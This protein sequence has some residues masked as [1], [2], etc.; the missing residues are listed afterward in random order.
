MKRL[1]I[2]FLVTDLGF[3]GNTREQFA[4]GGSRCSMP[5]INIKMA[6]GRNIQQKQQLVEI[7]TKA[8]AEILN[9]KEEWVTVIFDEYERDSWATGGSL[10]STKY[11]DG[12]GKM[13][14][15]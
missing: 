9:V 3:L 12:S 2:F 11:G 7:I 1:K 15:E 10:H 5:I 14:T 6:K 8:S 13:G 4:D